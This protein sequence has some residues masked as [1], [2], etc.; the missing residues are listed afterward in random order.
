M[1]ADDPKLGHAV[2]HVVGC[3][4]FEF[5]IPVVRLQNSPTVEM[6]VKRLNLYMEFGLRISDGMSDK[7]LA[8]VTREMMKEMESHAREG[9]SRSNSGG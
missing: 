2:Y 7:E 5:S 1:W 8:D 3:H 4:L 6:M 9:Q